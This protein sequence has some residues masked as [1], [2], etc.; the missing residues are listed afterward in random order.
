M[1]VGIRHNEVPTLLRTWALEGNSAAKLTE[2]AGPKG[3][4]FSVVCRVPL[5]NPASF[6]YNADNQAVEP[7]KQE[8]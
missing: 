8:G 2:P 4:L 7:T 1:R 6:L 5:E 3:S